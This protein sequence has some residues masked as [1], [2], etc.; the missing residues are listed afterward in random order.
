[1]ANV[2]RHSTTCH[3]PPHRERTCRLARPAPISSI[4]GC[5]QKEAEIDEKKSATYTVF[6]NIQPADPL[7]T[8][9]RNMS[10]APIPNPDRRLV[11]WELYR[12]EILAL[13]PQTQ[14][15]IFNCDGSI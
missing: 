6:P 1:M 14:S 11:K 9:G 2:H 7:T 3:K 5:V 4:T 8:V 10:R 15:T 13:P 12:P